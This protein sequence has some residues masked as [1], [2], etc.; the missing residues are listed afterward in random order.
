MFHAMIPSVSSVPL[1]A[2]RLKSSVKTLINRL[3]DFNDKTCE[4]DANS[5]YDKV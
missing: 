2:E 5:L 1:I 4:E 3:R